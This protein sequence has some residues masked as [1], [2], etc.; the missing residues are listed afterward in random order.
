MLIVGEKGGLEVCKQL[1]TA[2]E[3]WS[4]PTI[5]CL[6]EPT[7][8]SVLAALDHGASHVLRVPFEDSIVLLKVIA[9]VEKDF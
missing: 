5:S 3:T 2:N 7:H 1:R 6:S 4:I 8:E 9:G